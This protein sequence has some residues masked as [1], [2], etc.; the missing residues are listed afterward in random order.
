M[1]EDAVFGLLARTADWHRTLDDAVVETSPPR[2]AARDML[3]YPDLHLPILEGVIST[4]VFGRHGDLIMSDGY[5]PDDRLWLTPD[6]NLQLGTIPDEPTA[7]DIAAARALFIDELLVDF[8]FVDESD[9][10]HA[11]A[12]MILPFIRRMIDGPSPMHLIEAPTMGSGKG[13]LANLISIVATG[14]AC[15]ARTLPESEDEASQD[16]HCRV[17]EGPPNH[18]VGQRQRSQATA[19]LVARF[20]ADLRPVDRPQARR[21]HHGLGAK[22]CRLADDGQ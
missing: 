3:A 7:E 16:A 10:S 12:A 19:L 17:D 13:L 15:E 9:R 2:D 20:G 22:S 5:H 6:A 8:P 11:I 14:T 4:P 1:D 18:P 21:V